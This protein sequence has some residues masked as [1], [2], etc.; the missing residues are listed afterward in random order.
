MYYHN[1]LQTSSKDISNMLTLVIEVVRFEAI[2]E[3]TFDYLKVIAPSNEDS[4]F[5]QA[6]LDDER[7]HFDELK[8]IYFALTGQQPAGDPPTFEVPESYSKG[9][10]DLFLQKLE[11][12]AIYKKIR[13]LSPFLAVREKVADFIHDE[14]RHLPMLNHILINKYDGERFYDYRTI[15]NHYPPTYS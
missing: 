3:L 15:P 11:I 6:M 14:L 4:K 13:K 5:L 1:Y 7:E 2:T 12:I 8:K 10:N 9:I